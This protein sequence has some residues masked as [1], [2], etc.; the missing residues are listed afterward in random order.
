MRSSLLKCLAASA[1]VAIST[2]VASAAVSV[3]IDPG[4]T[5]NGYMNWFATPADG[6]GYV[7][8]GGWGTGDLRATFSGPVLTMAPNTNIDRDV[9]TDPYWWKGDGSANKILEANMYIEDSTGTLSGTNVTFAG[10]VVANTLVPQYSVIAFIKDFAPDYS[11]NVITTVP[12]TSGN[13]SVVVDSVAGAGRH[14]QYG[15]ALVGP[16]QRQTDQFGNIQVTAV[17]PEPASL[18]AITI[19]GLLLRR[20]R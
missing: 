12:V 11:S 15:L 10:S 7:G 19:A 3:T 1:L 18:G 5:W 2:S 16:P 9:P 13:F 14:V 4:A 17:V 8:G 20:R 6:G